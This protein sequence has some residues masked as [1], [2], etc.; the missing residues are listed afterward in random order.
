MNGHNAPGNARSQMTK[1]Q[2]ATDKRTPVKP[3]NGSVGEGISTVATE[4]IWRLERTETR[5]SVDFI[6]G[7]LTSFP[8]WIGAGDGFWVGSPSSMQGQDWES[9]QQQDFATA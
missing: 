2:N 3:T 4:G 5:V 8:L 7:I 9:E 1:L 6:A